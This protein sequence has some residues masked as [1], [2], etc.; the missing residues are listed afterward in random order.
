MHSGVLQP[1]GFYRLLNRKKHI[2]MHII[3][4]TI[5]TFISIT[6]DRQPHRFNSRSRYLVHVSS[7]HLKAL[8][9][10]VISSASS[11]RAANDDLTLI[12]S[13]LLDEAC[14]AWGF[15]LC[16]YKIQVID[17]SS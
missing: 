1:L 17:L 9:P 6:I 16:L 11:S 10:G 14:Q 4:Y 5:Y 3:Y 13:S 2:H 15:M 8:R 7:I 12:Q